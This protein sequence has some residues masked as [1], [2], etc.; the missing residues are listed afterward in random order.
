MRMSLL[1]GASLLVPRMLSAQD[2]WRPAAVEVRPF[3]GM[4][5]PTGAQRADFT[6]ATIIGIQGAMEFN[7]HVHAVGSV[8]RT[9]GR[10]KLFAKDGTNIWQYDVGA[11]LNLVRQIR[12]EWDLRPFVGAGAGGRTYEYRAPGVGTRSCY[13]GYATAGAE[14]Q[15]ELVA[16]RAEARDYLSCFDSPVTGVKRTRNDLG[17]TVGVA[18]HLR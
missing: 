12:V 3:A 5:L 8:G 7:R 4:F 16:F 9:H 14:L 1:L 11:E 18:Y 10:N 15:R 2:V 17:L 13:A 6:S